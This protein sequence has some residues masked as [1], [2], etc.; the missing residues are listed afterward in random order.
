MIPT[1]VPLPRVVIGELRGE[2]QRRRAQ[3]SKQMALGR[4]VCTKRSRIGRIQF[5]KF[6]RIKRQ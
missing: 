4:L 2:A 5:L 3:S 6:L 1:G